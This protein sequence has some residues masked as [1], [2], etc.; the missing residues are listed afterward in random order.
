MTS[1]RSPRVEPVR[2]PRLRPSDERAQL[3]AAARSSRRIAV[4]ALVVAL[5]ALGLTAWRF[6][7]AP[8]SGAECQAAAWDAQ[9]AVADLPLGWTISSSQYDIDRKQ[10]TLLGPVPSDGTSGQPVLYATVTCYRDGA[11]ESVSRSAAAA[12]AAGQS[13]TPR[14]DLGD[15][16][17]LAA[18][19]SGAVFLQ[20]RRD[21]VVVYLAASGDA[22]AGEIEAVAFAFDAAMGGAAGAAPIG[23]PDLGSPAFGTPAF[24]TPAPSEALVS[25]GASEEPGPSDSPAA[26]DLEA[27][28][29]T[30]VGDVTLTVQSAVGT[31]ILG[32]DQGSRAIIAALRAEGRTPDDLRVARGYDPSG[33]SDL[34]ILAVSVTGMKLDAVKSLVMSAWLAA[35]GAGVTMDAVTLSGH[36]FTRI[37]YGDGGSIEYLLA[38]NDRVLIIE[39]ADATIAAQAAAALP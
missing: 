30:Q 9:P 35:S 14:S 15:Q 18:D 31:S 12:T 20:F 39:T 26:P 8:S 37:D 36:E 2:E 32:D 11:A 23:T 27:A 17:Y 7:A 21:D 6:L 25:P 38:E 34:T 1:P 5:A 3:A 29:P 4:A 33:N 19:A 10:M 24:G 28:L 22:T 16:G 13:V